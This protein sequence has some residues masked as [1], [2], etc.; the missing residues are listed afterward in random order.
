MDRRESA[1]LRYTQAEAC[2]YNR[3]TIPGGRD[4]RVSSILSLERRSGMRTETF[5][6]AVAAILALA[7][8]ALPGL[9]QPMSAD[10]QG[11]PLIEEMLILDK[12]FRDVVSGVALGSGEAV[13]KALHAMHGT[14]EKTHEGVHAG[15]VKLPKNADRMEEFVAMDKK[16]HQDLESLAHAAHMNDQEQMLALTKTLLDACVRCHQKFR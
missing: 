4:R 11:N 6:G 9:F 8:T 16:F 14:M 13:H 1:S 2:D 3:L 10:A 12:V 5:R 7:L 15:A